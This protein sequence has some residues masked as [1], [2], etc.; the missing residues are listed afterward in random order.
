M[1]WFSP[2]IVLLFEVD[3]AVAVANP[4]FLRFIPMQMSEKR[5]ARWYGRIKSYKLFAVPVEFEVSLSCT[6]GVAYGRR[7]C[8]DKVF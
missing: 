4:R 1:L 7:I 3:F 6:S 2:T 8:K 5:G